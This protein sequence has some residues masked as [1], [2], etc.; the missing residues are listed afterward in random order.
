V[1]QSVTVAPFLNGAAF[2]RLAA[3][4]VNFADVRNCPDL[5]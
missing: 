1:K 4:E 2:E 5:K 3:G